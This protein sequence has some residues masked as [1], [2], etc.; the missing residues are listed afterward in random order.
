MLKSN[1]GLRKHYVST[2]PYYTTS[3][4]IF[5][6]FIKTIVGSDFLS[7]RPWQSRT[8][9][10]KGV[11]GWSEM[12]DTLLN[13]ASPAEF[14]GLFISTAAYRLTLKR[15][16]YSSLALWETIKNTPLNPIYKLSDRLCVHGKLHW[17]V[18][19]IKGTELHRLTMW[20]ERFQVVYK[21]RHAAC[22]T[23]GKHVCTPS[24]H[25]LSVCHPGLGG[26]ALCLRGAAISSPRE[27]VNRAETGL[28][29]SIVFY[30]SN[31]TRYWNA[32]VISMCAVV[33]WERRVRGVEGFKWGEVFTLCQSENSLIKYFDG[34]LN[35]IPQGEGHRFE[36][37][38]CEQMAC[39]GFLPQSKTMHV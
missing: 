31:Q 10:H 4:F 19:H 27:H 28:V 25:C 6:P 26:I 20:P 8:Y 34:S 11:L 23:Q 21:T 33:Y 3:F 24:N 22:F 37:W 39:S 1:W 13:S 18:Q 30:S 32:A 7:G 38:E 2:P 17:V 15:H 29:T 14:V 16:C 5:L 9:K 36:S 35:G 12:W